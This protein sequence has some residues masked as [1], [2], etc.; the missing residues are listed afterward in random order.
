MFHS[1][2]DVLN[3]GCC[4]FYICPPY[5]REIHQKDVLVRHPSL[6]G[7][8]LGGWGEAFCFIYLSLIKNPV[9]QQRY[10]D[11]FTTQL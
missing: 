2:I 9:K 7:K 11:P 10:A 4:L 6:W 8:E 5:Q 3:H 1:N